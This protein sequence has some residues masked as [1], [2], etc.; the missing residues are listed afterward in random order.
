MDAAGAL[1]DLTEISSQV[2][3]AVV[4]GSGG[5][6]LGATPAD[7]DAARRLADAAGALLEAAAET[8]A[9]A[10]RELTQ[11]EVALPEASLFVVR[12]AERAIVATTSAEPPS[13][14]V[15]YDLRACLRALEA[16]PRPKPRGR[17]PRAKAPDRGA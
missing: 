14:L 11:L 3:A 15:L 2:E 5:D 10:G 6:V 1:A 8:P 7:E 13:A 9:G 4:V 16:P 17:R 12:D